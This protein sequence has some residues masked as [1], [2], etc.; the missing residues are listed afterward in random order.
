[1]SCSNVLF[2][3]K[4]L[5]DEAYYNDHRDS[6]KDALWADAQGEGV[7]PVDVWVSVGTKM[8]EVNE[9]V[10]L[11]VLNVVHTSSESIAIADCRHPNE[12][13][14]IQELGGK[15]YYVK[16]SRVKPNPK[17]KMDLLITEDMC[18]GVIENEGT[19]EELYEKLDSL[20]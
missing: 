8:R 4:G 12:L 2:A 7:T 20:I 6:R 18:D 9:D 11:D 10:W 3:H 5:K 1:L 13:K 17:A 15:V 16:N 19:L 14:R